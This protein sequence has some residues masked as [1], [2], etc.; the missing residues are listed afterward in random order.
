MPEPDIRKQDQKIG[1]ETYI[2]ACNYRIRSEPRT[3]M[4]I[5]CIEL[6]NLV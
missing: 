5:R 1:Q 2:K 6:N 3:V 4:I